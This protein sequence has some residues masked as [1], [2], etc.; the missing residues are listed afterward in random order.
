VVRSLARG[1][2]FSLHVVG[3]EALVAEG[4]DVTL[5]PWRLESEADD[6]RAMDVGVMPLPDGEW[7]EG[8]CALKLLQY[9]SAG[10]ATVSTP[11]RAVCDIVEDGVNGFLA[12][13]DDEWRERLGTLLSDPTL[14]RRMGERARQ[15][16]ESHYSLAN[17][18]PRLG[19][20]LR[21]A[22]RGEGCG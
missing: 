17:Y 19:A 3:D 22:T 11:T 1:V 4:I 9:M 8:K 16:V 2:D 5:R 18:G 6:L 21:A 10:L 14:R 15:W 7:A 20:H 13:N 12:R